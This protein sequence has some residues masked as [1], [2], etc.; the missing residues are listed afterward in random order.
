MSA[1]ELELLF[2]AIAGSSDTV[3]RRQFEAFFKGSNTTKSVSSQINGHGLGTLSENHRESERIEALKSRILDHLLLNEEDAITEM[4]GIDAVEALQRIEYCNE[5]A[6]AMKLNISQITDDDN[7]AVQKWSNRHSVHQSRISSLSEILLKFTADSN[8]EN[9]QKPPSPTK[10]EDAEETLSEIWS[11]YFRENGEDPPNEVA[12]Y[13]WSKSSDSVDALT[14]RESKSIFAMK[15][16]LKKRKSGQSTESEKFGILKK[17]SLC[18]SDEDITNS[19]DLES[20]KFGTS[21][22]SKMV[23][24]KDKKSNSSNNSNS[25]KSSDRKGT[26]TAKTSRKRSGTESSVTPKRRHNRSRTATRSELEVMDKLEMDGDDF[27]SGSSS[28]GM[29]SRLNMS[30]EK[31]TAMLANTVSVQKKEI[32]RMRSELKRLEEEVQSERVKARKLKRRHHR[33][34]ST[35]SMMAKEESVAQS[36]A[37]QRDRSGLKMEVKRL[38]DQLQEEED[39]NRKLRS[40]LAH[41]E[42]E[43]K[44]RERARSKKETNS[45]SA[46]LQGKVKRMEK[47]AERLK[48]EMK[49]K[50]I[51]TEQ[52]IA[53]WKETERLC[54]AQKD[55][56][57]KL[58]VELM[59]RERNQQKLEE[60][61]RSLLEQNEDLQAELQQMEEDMEQNKETMNSLEDE[62]QRVVVEKDKLV[63]ELAV[64][65]EPQLSVQRVLSSTSFG[66]HFD[67][68]MIERVALAEHHETWTSSTYTIGLVEVL[69][70]C[71]PNALSNDDDE[72]EED[73]ESEDSDRDGHLLIW[74][75]MK[76]PVDIQFNIESPQIGFEC[77]AEMEGIGNRFQS[78]A[79]GDPIPHR[80]L[81]HLGDD[82]LY[83]ICSI[84]FDE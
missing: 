72:D 81:E 3:T 16:K 55:D 20:P 29:A 19:L 10:E 70:E 42:R 76:G 45:G 80:M 52:L 83:L 53:S 13:Q 17:H 74:I 58:E 35:M 49:R 79:V 60:R 4:D 65:Y 68:G 34:S 12:L 36:A 61:C 54:R 57:A 40:K 37:T 66:W 56:V 82:G 71:T 27:R 23:K 31:A 44:Q 63:R 77:S 1:S 38:R 43:Q 14:F 32:K 73:E 33:K 78:V 30:A 5:M 9:H 62:H 8:E 69:M 64:C 46:I 7:D 84:S 28:M 50:E 39:R 2:N 75:T 15:R 59:N 18:S 25:K 47:E 22:K 67:R 26:K 6:E 11:L 24:L 41:K 51:R 21:R 48:E